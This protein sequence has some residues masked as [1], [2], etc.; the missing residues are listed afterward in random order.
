MTWDSFGL[1]EGD[2]A[3]HLGRGGIDSR[4]ASDPE[5]LTSAPAHPAG[6]GLGGARSRKAGMW[7]FATNRAA[8]KS[9]LPLNSQALDPKQTMAMGH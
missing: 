6:A 2:R 4:R 1:G 9:N 8:D 3:D 7:T 5:G